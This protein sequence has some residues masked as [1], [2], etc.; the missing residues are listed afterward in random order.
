MNLR[1]YLSFVTAGR[2]DDLG[3]DSLSRINSFVFN[4]VSL[5]ERHALHSELLLVD[6]NPMPSRPRLADVIDWPQ[7]PL[8][9]VTIQVIEVPPAVHYRLPNSYQQP[10]FEHVAKNVGVRRANGEFVLVTTPN[11]L[12]SDQL[13]RQLATMRLQAGN[14]YRTARYDV[15]GSVPQNNVEEQLQYCKE[16]ILRMHGYWYSPKWDLQARWNP[17][18][19]LRALSGYVKSQIRN[20]SLLN[21]YVNA[22]SDFFLMHRGDWHDLR[23][24][25]EIKSNSYVDGYLTYCAHFSGRR[26]K[27]LRGKDL[28]LFHQEHRPR[29]HQNC[30]LTDLHEFRRNCEHMARLRTAIIFNDSDWGM[31][32]ANLSQVQ[33]KPS[34]GRDIA[35]AIS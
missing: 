22:A 4:L 30:S 12:F 3:R 31:A 17:Y 26:L 6:W 24:Y 2:N 25:P 16:N 1:P 29:Q 5:C 8:K 21:P 18:W 28:Y 27:I 14:Y 13:I 23:G 35:M 32:R 11:V 34:V 7:L 15:R 20:R 19:R 10:F 33:I 9:H